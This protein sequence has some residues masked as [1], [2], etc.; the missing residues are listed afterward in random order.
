MPHDA[1]F[2]VILDF[3]QWHNCYLPSINASRINIVD[4]NGLRD[5]YSKSENKCMYSNKTNSNVF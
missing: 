1:R 2:C 4:G 3:D 5:N